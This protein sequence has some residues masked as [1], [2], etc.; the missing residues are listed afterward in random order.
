MKTT[1]ITKYPAALVKDLSNLFAQKSSNAPGY[2]SLHQLID[3]FNSYGSIDSYAVNGSKLLNQDLL[4][5]SRHDYVFKKFSDLNDTF[6]LSEAIASFNES[7]APVRELTNSINSIFNKYRIPSPLKD[8]DYSIGQLS[9]KP[10]DAILNLA[11]DNTIKFPTPEMQKGKT[12]HDV[13]FDEIP[14]NA[15]IAFISYS[16][17]NDAHKEWVRKLSDAL[18]QHGVFTLFDRYIPKGYPL[19]R[20]M[21]RGIDIADRVI[22]V[23]SPEYLRK[24][25]NLASGGAPY[26][27]CIISSELMT[28]IATT[29]YLPVIHGGSFDECLPAKLSKRLGIDFGD[30]SLFDEKIDELVRTI[31]GISE[32]PR[33]ALGPVP[34][35]KSQPKPKQEN[36]KTTEPQSDFRK[37]QDRKWLDRLLESFSFDL[38]HNYLCD[39]PTYV[40][41]RAFMSF[42]MW[43]GIVS[44]PNFRIYDQKLQRMITEFLELWNKDTHIGVSYY[45]TTKTKHRLR[46]HGLQFDT[47]TSNKAEKDFE[48]IIKIHLQMQPLLKELAVYIQD[49]YEIDVEETS[50]KF[51]KSLE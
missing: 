49:N 38:M 8:I 6:H 23:G 28:D 31:Y 32:C 17:D 46:F 33:P 30:D 26:E 7:F 44:L 47:F 18:M 5:L 36:V 12:P 34:D 21:D 19:T 16:W 2:L 29:K 35:F 15:K 11:N 4:G 37:K 27:N 22:V 13:V 20:F 42:D 9:I 14:D 48:E 1:P 24:C 41:D 3:M 25:N 45:D 43:N 39:Y 10:T 51:I 50:H 40:D